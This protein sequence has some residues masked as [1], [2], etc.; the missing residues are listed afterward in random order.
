MLF[1]SRHYTQHNDTQH[2]NEI[3]YNDTQNKGLI[4]ETQHNKATRMLNVIKLSVAFYL[5][6]C[7]VSSCWISFCWVSLCW[8]SWHRSLLMLG[9]VI[10]ETQHNK[11]TSMLCHLGECHI[12]FIVM[13]N[14]VML[15]VVLSLCWMPLCW[16]SWHRSLLMLGVVILNVIVLN[17]IMLT[18]IVLSGIML[19]DLY[20]NDG[21]MIRG[22]SPWHFHSY[23][24]F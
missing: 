20:K 16:V 19:N 18:V 10:R 8:V 7:C 1:V 5:L 22:T 24:F 14:V 13:L 3:R 6:L 15:R 9:V 12:L 2:F 17:G 4:G 23:Y 11:A 21:K